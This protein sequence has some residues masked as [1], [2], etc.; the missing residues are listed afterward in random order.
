MSAMTVA[1]SGYA[2][3]RW[4]SNSFTLPAAISSSNSSTIAA[5]RGANPSTARLVKA[6]PI[7][8]RRRVCRGGSLNTAQ[9]ARFS[10]SGSTSSRSAPSSWPTNGRMRSDDRRGS[11]KPARTS[12][13]RVTTQAPMRSER[14][15]GAASCSRRSTG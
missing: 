5:M 12:A 14:N 8:A 10:Q 13:W 15:T 6:L 1:G 2:N 11:R 3:A 7:N 9:S 4:K